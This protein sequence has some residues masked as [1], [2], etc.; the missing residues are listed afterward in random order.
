MK[1]E[2]LKPKSF[3]D[4]HREAEQKPLDS[5]G[6]VIP[7]T[8]KE[9]AI[10][11]E[12]KPVDANGKV[13]ESQTERLVMKKDDLD[14]LITDDC[15]RMGV[16]QEHKNETLEDL[17]DPMRDSRVTQEQES[18]E[19]IDKFDIFEKIDD[20]TCS[21]K[22]EEQAKVVVG[23]IPVKTQFAQKRNAPFF[24]FKGTSEEKKKLWKEY[25][26][27]RLKD[28]EKRQKEREQRQA[29]EKG[30]IDSLIPQTGKIKPNIMSNFTPIGKNTSQKV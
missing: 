20:I 10:R 30:Q 2:L 15:K 6:K 17:E 25:E 14:E 13:I 26:N 24:P 29:Q 9:I 22:T 4:I 27:S 16:I 12:M 19:M 7:Q 21:D 3:A 28:I 18:F 5:N 23:R 1:R 11:A 8:L